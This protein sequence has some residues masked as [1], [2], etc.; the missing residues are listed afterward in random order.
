M[1]V[2]VTKLSSM[3]TLTGP[4][5]S[6][7]SLVFFTLASMNADLFIFGTHTYLRSASKG[8]SGNCDTVCQSVTR[9][10]SVTLDTIR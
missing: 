9:N 1:D 7:Y 6:S 2:F 8:K 5:K 4:A 10:G 3:N